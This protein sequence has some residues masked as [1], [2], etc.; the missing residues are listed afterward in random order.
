MK[1]GWKAT[2][3][4]PKRVIDMNAYRRKVMTLDAYDRLQREMDRAQLEQRAEV[5]RKAREQL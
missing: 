3:G 5:E 1:T 2:A 4:Q